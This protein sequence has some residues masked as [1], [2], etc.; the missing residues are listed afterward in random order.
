MLERLQRLIDPK[1]LEVVAVSIDEGGK[2]GVRRFS[3]ARTSRACGPTSIPRRGRQP[4]RS[5]FPAPF[6]LYGLPISYL[7]DRQGR[8]AGISPARPI[9]PPP[10]GS[11][12]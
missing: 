3:N 1:S 4:R 10:M 11:L 2:P 12:C 9:G 8:V 5:G 6:I 7:I